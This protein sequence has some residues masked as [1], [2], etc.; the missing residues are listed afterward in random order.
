MSFP[1]V[2]FGDL[3]ILPNSITYKFLDTKK[4]SILKEIK[5]VKPFPRSLQADAPLSLNS[6]YNVHQHKEPKFTTY[7]KKSSG[8]FSGTLDYIF[9]SPNLI[10]V[11][12]L[13]IPS[14]DQL[15]A[16]TT[17]I[18]NKMMP[19]DHVPIS[20]KFVINMKYSE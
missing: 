5:M 17:G 4:I 7:A 2:L 16:V 10:P 13:R 20:A 14:E 12:T 18:P 9:Y 3:N 11:Q 19:S 6:V 1:V 8:N 15:D